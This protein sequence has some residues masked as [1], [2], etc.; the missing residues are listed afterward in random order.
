MYVQVTERIFVDAF[1]RMGRGDDFS[2]DGLVALFNY[3]E[4]LEYDGFGMELD[5]ITICC[6][7]TEL[8]YS[9]AFEDYSDTFNDDFADAFD[10][11]TFDCENAEHK[12]W[13]IS[14]LN[15]NTSVVAAL[16][17]SIVFCN[18]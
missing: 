18:F 5:V 10:A 4:E 3:F 9:A 16:D 6:D 1:V 17:D 7:Y 11:A 8:S 12:A 13:L 14:A 15:D 2:Y